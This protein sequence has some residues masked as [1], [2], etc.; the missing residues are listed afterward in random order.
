[1]KR[2]QKYGNKPRDNAGERSDRHRKFLNLRPAGAGSREKKI[3]EKIWKTQNKTKLDLFK[4]RQKLSDNWKKH[5]DHFDLR[6]PQVVKK[7]KFVKKHK[8]TREKSR[9]IEKEF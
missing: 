4:K 2:N 3:R 6:L 5:S 7:P 8:N 1:L 9:T